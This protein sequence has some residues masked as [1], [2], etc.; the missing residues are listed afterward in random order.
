MKKFGTP[1]GD[2]PGNEN[3]KV[4][5]AE[6]GTPPLPFGEGGLVVFFLV[7]PPE[8]DLPLL[9]PG[10]FFCFFPPLGEVGLVGW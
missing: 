3:E 1:I 10:F 4:G 8:P 9:G 6:V 2:G 5:F 7:L